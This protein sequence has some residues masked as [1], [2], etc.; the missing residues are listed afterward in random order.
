MKIGGQGSLS[1]PVHCVQCGEHFIV[2]DRGE[3]CIKVF[4]R[5]RHFQ[6]KFGKRGEGDGEFNCPSYLLVNESQHLF[7]CDQKNHRVQVFELNG[8]FI[9]KFGT[10]GSKLGEFIEPILV[11][12]LSNG[13]IVVCDKDNH[14]IQKFE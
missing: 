7:V 5:E 11:E 8:K 2:S 1:Y 4:N 9:G 14:R 3:H 10:N 12:M 13:Q 6:Y